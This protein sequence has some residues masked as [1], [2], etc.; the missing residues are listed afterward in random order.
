MFP[1]KDLKR[2]TPRCRKYLRI[3]F[4][5]QRLFKNW[6]ILPELGY[7][8]QGR[9]PLPC[10]FHGGLQALPLRIHCIVDLNLYLFP[11]LMLT[12]WNRDALKF[13]TLRVLGYC[14]LIIILELQFGTE[15]ASV[16]VGAALSFTSIWYLCTYVFFYILFFLHFKYS[17]SSKFI[18]TNDSVYFKFSMQRD[19][20]CYVLSYLDHSS[21]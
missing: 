11:W 13:N 17:F 19:N 1:L 2:F 16:D 15:P 5:A 6:T 21:C 7:T 18:F 12:R 3:R 9:L 14:I 8:W 20:V 10:I 4:F